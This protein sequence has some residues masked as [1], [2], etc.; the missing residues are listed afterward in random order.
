M[1][2]RICG[3]ERNARYRASKL[4]FLCKECNKDTPK[5]ISYDDFT[6]KFWRNDDNV[7]FSM[8]RE[9]YQDYL[10]SCCTYDEYVIAV[11]G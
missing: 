6:E 8:K 11:T 4:Q 7:P 1:Y 5:K 10:S 9:F 2:C 3:S